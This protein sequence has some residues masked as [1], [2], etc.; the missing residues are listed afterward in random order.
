M[1]LL[2]G[3]TSNDPG[4]GFGAGFTYVFNA[5]SV[6]DERSSRRT[7]TATTSCSRPQTARGRT[8]PALARAM[9]IAITASAPTA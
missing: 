7:P 5:F 1:P 9:C 8:D 3:L 6:P 2:F 4:V